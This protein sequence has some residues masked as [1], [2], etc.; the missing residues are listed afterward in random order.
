M[1]SDAL[2]SDADVEES[3]E[4]HASWALLDERDADGNAIVTI[5][6]E[7]D[8]AAAQRL[9]KRLLCLLAQ[10]PQRMVIRLDQ[11]TFLD[12]TGLSVFVAVQHR[13]DNAGVELRLVAPAEA[14]RR[15]L[16]LTAMDSYFAIYPTVEDALRSSAAE[17]SDQQDR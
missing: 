2:P 4:V 12:S 5:S 8:L 15:V 9:R 13:A 6:G 17:T 10:G 7:V 16:Q 1:S 3:R 11:M 14:P